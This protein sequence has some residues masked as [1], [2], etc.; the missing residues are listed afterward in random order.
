MGARREGLPGKRTPD[1]ILTRLRNTA[2]GDIVAAIEALPD[3]RTIDLG[4]LLL[5]LSEE[6][7]T[8]L[9]R[10]IRHICASSRR[11]GKTHDI[12]IGLGDSSDGLTVHCTVADLPSAQ[13]LLQTHCEG[14]KY[15]QKADRWFGL[16]L[17][18]DESLRFG[19]QLEFPWAH[20][21]RLQ[22]VVE[23]LPKAP[24][25]RPSASVSKR[26][27]KTGRNEP[28]PCGSGRKYK[29]CCLVG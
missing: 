21:D 10:G 4:L 8:E 23:Q 28:C 12:T 3:A 9:S 24:V 17:W 18:P 27:S 6:T 5:E 20:D 25:R 13:Q 29:R 15:S 19:V 22:R 7:A 26:V 16:A 1:G 14:R 2:I 11:D